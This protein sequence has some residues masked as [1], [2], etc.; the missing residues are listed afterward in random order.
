MNANPEKFLHIRKNPFKV[1]RS[2]KEGSEIYDDSS[3]SEEINDTV[4]NLGSE[5]C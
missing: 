1:S 4:H 3:D 2:P 5:G